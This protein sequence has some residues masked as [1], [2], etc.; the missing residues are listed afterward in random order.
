MISSKD[1]AH[2]FMLDGEIVS[3]PELCIPA[4]WPAMMRG[5]SIFEA[6]LVRNGQLPIHIDDHDERLCFSARLTGFSVKEGDL[7]DGLT[8]F[9]P[10]L[11]KGDWR[12]RCTVLRGVESQHIMFSAGPELPPPKEVAL[13]LSPYRLDPYDPLAGAKTSSRMMYQCARHYAEEIGA[14][15]A[16]LQTI[17][18]D[19]AEGT[20]TNF[21]VWTGEKIITPSLNRGILG[22][23]TRLNVLRSLKA[24]DILCEESRVETFD[25]EQALEVY[26]TNAVI[27]LIPATK[28]KGIERDFPGLQGSKLEEVRQAYSQFLYQLT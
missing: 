7:R 2:L 19:W 27:G 25:L 22:G 20:S 15:E 24:R 11:K 8:R 4:V 23:V 5:E 9:I 6:F 14:Y 28:I 21:F 13:C 26:I 18:G 16:L 12:V 3:G 10:F 17:D 1:L